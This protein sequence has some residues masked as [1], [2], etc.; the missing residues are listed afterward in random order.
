MKS[1]SQV[2]QDIMVITTQAHKKKAEQSLKGLNAYIDITN[3]LY[4]QQASDRSALMIGE[5]HIA[6]AYQATLLWTLRHNGPVIS[7]DFSPD[8]MYISN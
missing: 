2:Q 6:T 5:S 4:D 1:L 7:I 3:P 8:S